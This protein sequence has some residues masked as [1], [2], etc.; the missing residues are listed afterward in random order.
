MFMGRPVT[1]C[2]NYNVMDLSPTAN[3]NKCVQFDLNKYKDIH[4]IKMNGS[5]WKNVVATSVEVN[6]CMFAIDL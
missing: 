4:M 6:L 2:L 1:F 3:I 5:C